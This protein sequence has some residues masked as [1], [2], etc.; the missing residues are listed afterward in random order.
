ME[1]RRRADPKNLWRRKQITGGG[2][3]GA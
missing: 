2:V 3:I 1:R